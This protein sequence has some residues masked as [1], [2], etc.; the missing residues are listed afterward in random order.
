LQSQLLRGDRV[1]SVDLVLDGAIYDRDEGGVIGAGEVQW[2]TAG[3]GIIHGENVATKGKVRLLQLWLTLPMSQRWTTPGFQDIHTSAVPVRREP[4]AEVRIYSGGSGDFQP[5][6]RNH[7]PVTMVEIV[8]DGRAGVD[9][10]VPISCNGFLYVIHGSVLVGEEAALLKTG[11]VGWLDRP[12][13]DGMS[14]VRVAAGEESARLV[15]YT[16]QPQGDRIVSHGPFIGDSRDDIIRLYT[17]YRAGRF[18]RMSDLAR[19]NIQQAP[20][21]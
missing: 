21:S 10:E 9:Q 3:T 13:G 20:A 12:D 17:E 15:L 16:G 8:L 5:A 7:V 2:M 14:V 18:K 19:M 6:T 11:Q 4:G 1:R